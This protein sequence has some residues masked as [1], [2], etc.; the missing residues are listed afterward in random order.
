MVDIK[1]RELA[2]IRQ[3]MYRQELDKQANEAYN[4][5]NAQKYQSSEHEQKMM[6]MQVG[7]LKQIE[8]NEIERE[9]KKRSMAVNMM[10]ENMRLKQK[11]IEDNKE[12]ERRENMVIMDRIKKT[13]EEERM[14][15]EYQKL[16]KV[17]IA[18][19]LKMSYDVQEGMKKQENDKR[20]E[21]DKMYSDEYQQK[22]IQDD[23]NRQQFF[24]YLKEKQVQNDE[25][26]KRYHFMVHAGL[27]EQQKQD[28]EKQLK[29]MREKMKL[30][31]EKEYRDHNAK[32]QVYYYICRLNK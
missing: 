21:L 18:N 6:Q 14:K 13:Q 27:M 28:E 22:L 19:A 32:I 5:A 24:D 15:I 10:D 17:K 12:A 4:R 9:M 3:D 11:T 20:K 29:A 2:R 26:G 31:Q 7:S 16:N 8:R 1:E 23:K 30:D 25:R